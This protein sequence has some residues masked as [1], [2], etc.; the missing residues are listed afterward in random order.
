[1]GRVLAR[2][3]EFRWDRSGENITTRR[4]QEEDSRLWW[5]KPWAPALAKDSLNLWLL[6]YKMESIRRMK[7][8][9]ALSTVSN[10]KDVFNEYFLI[11]DYGQQ[12]GGKT[13]PFG[14]I[15]QQE[16]AKKNLTFLWPFPPLFL[17]IL[18]F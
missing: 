3:Q 6:I 9:K 15:Y 11:K 5:L 4:R 12:N 13:S 8:Q 7:E 18:A 17:M 1:L 14:N 10:I 2:S 16:T